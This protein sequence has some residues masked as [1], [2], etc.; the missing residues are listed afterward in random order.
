VVGD[1][2][3]SVGQTENGV[4]NLLKISSGKEKYEVTMKTYSTDN[5]GLGSIMF[6]FF[7]SCSEYFLSSGKVDKFTISKEEL[8]GFLQMQ[9]VPVKVGG[10]LYWSSSLELSR[11]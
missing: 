8:E 10:E 4:P 1:G 3:T 7:D 11:I 5:Y 2:S 9:E 6:P